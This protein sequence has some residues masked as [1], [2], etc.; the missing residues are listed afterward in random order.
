MQWPDHFPDDCP[1]ENALSAS[2]EVYR[3][4]R[5]VPPKKLDFKSHRENQPNRKFNAPECTVCGLSV[6]TDTEDIHRLRRRGALQAGDKII[7]Q[8]S[9]LMSHRKS[10][11]GFLI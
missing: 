11:F 5:K 1:P 6:Y 4:V 10:L 3:L 7:E 2:G 9:R 8:S